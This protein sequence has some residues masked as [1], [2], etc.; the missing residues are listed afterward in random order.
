MRLQDK[1]IIIP[2]ETHDGEP[3]MMRFRFYGSVDRRRARR[4]IQKNFKSMGIRCTKAQLN[5]LIKH[6]QY[7]IYGNREQNQDVADTAG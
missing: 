6:R 3:A 1:G 5:W 2:F 4:M 7:D